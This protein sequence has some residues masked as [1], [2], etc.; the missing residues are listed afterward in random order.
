MAFKK[1]FLF[2]AV[3]ASDNEKTSIGGFPIVSPDVFQKTLAKTGAF[4]TARDNEE[5]FA[6]LIQTP[7]GV[8]RIAGKYWLGVPKTLSFFASREEVPV[9]RINGGK[10]H[11]RIEPEGIHVAELA[12][13]LRPLVNS[14]QVKANLDRYKMDDELGPDKPLAGANMLKRVMVVVEWDD[15]RMAVALEVVHHDCRRMRTIGSFRFVFLPE[16]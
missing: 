10:D 7:E 8:D 9:R 13:S 3:N 12:K 5:R 16:P 11:N 4:G 1:A 2:A 14:D 15:P 6:R